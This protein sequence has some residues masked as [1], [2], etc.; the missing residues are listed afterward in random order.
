MFFKMTLVMKYYQSLIVIIPQYKSKEPFI[1]ILFE[2]RPIRPVY[3][4]VPG[5][6]ILFLICFFSYFFFHHIS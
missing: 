3:L 6:C 4:V 2:K 5:V 1:V